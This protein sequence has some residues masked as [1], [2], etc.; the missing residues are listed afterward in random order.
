MSCVLYVVFLVFRKQLFGFYI[1]TV[2]VVV[3]V[4]VAIFVVIVIV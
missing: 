1:V 3:V 2:S 4:V